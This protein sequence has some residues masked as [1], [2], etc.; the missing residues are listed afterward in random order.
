MSAFFDILTG[1]FLINL[2]SS[3]SKLRIRDG[4]CIE[5]R[6]GRDIRNFKNPRQTF[7]SQH[8]RNVQAK[9]HRNLP[10]FG[11]LLIHLFD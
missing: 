2:S 1:H 8:L 10:N 5:D 9:F 4:H 3:S 6:H 7:V 11:T